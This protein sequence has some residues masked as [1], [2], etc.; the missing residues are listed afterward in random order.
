MASESFTMW[1]LIISREIYI[2]LVNLVSVRVK[3]H[4]TW[5]CEDRIGSNIANWRNTSGCR[6]D[7]WTEEED[8]ASRGLYSKVKGKRLLFSQISGNSIDHC[9][10]EQISRSDLMLSRMEKLQCAVASFVIEFPCIFQ[11]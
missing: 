7:A 11:D 4:I 10:I 5:L 6:K 9:F 3:Y 2:S 8:E 1:Y